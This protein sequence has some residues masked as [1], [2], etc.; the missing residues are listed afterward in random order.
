MPVTG[1]VINLHLFVNDIAAVIASY[2]E[3]QVYRSEVGPDGPWTQIA[4]TASVAQVLGDNTSEP[5]LIN[6]KTLL[7]KFNNLT[8]FTTTFVSVDPA[9]AAAVAA[10][11]DAVVTGT[12]T[13]IASGGRV[14]VSSVLMGTQ[15]SVEVTGGTGY[16]NLGF[17]LADFGLGTTDAITLV[18]GTQDYSFSDYNGSAD[19][20][21]RTRYYNSGS[22]AASEFSVP[23]PA[24]AVRRLPSTDLITGTC[25][26]I[27]L[28]GNALAN[29]D[30]VVVNLWEPSIHSGYGVFGCEERVTTDADGYAE[31]TVIKGSLIDVF[32]PGTSVRRRIRVP[33]TGSSFDLLGSG[34]AEDEFGIQVPVLRVAERRFP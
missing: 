3:M 23:M 21:Y 16:A 13:A 30:V 19:Y 7:L 12:G 25:S 9:D 24:T 4:G 18:A 26:L 22:G 17:Q 2:D 11:I 10:E 5:F 32:F 20:W 15:A 31:V 14:L 27:D 8:T 34:L 1:T 6:G 28:R 29:Q 33:D